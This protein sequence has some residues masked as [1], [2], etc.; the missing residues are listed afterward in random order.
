MKISKISGYTFGQNFQLLPPVCSDYIRHLRISFGGPSGLKKKAILFGPADL[1]ATK[2][3]AIL[4]I[5]P[6]YELNLGKI[7]HRQPF[8]FNLSC[9]LLQ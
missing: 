8:H 4:P 5:L 6:I 3:N 2:K 9:E 7:T 1:A